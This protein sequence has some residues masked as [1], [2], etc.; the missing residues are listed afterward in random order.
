MATDPE[1]DKIS[2]TQV[3]LEAIGCDCFDFKDLGTGSFRIEVITNKL[4]TGQFNGNY[5][6]EIELRD[7]GSRIIT[8]SFG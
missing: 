4:V 1:K 8:N 5:S 7:N 3:G 2:L 6:L